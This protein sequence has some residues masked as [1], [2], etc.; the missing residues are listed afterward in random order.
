MPQPPDVLKGLEPPKRLHYN[1]SNAVLFEHLND[2][3]RFN[4]TRHSFMAGDAVVVMRRRWHLS[5]GF[6]RA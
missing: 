3:E 4:H 5:L 1:T 6:G 2:W